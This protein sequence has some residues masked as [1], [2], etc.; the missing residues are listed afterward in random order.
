L[1]E[2]C[3]DLKEK[4]DR[5]IGELDDLKNSI[6]QEHI[7]GFEKGLRQVAFFMRESMLRT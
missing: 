5:A 7:N 1:E 4:Y 2:D 6:I 3:D